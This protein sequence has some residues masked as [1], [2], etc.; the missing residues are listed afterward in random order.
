MRLLKVFRM[1]YILYIILFVA[2]FNIATSAN[3]SAL[4]YQKNVNVQF[5]FGPTLNITLSSADLIIPN[6]APGTYDDSNI[7]TVNVE[8]NATYGYT[9]SAAT[10]N[11]STYTNT[12]LVNSS[13]SDAT[14]KK[15]TSL[16]TTASYASMASANDNYW[17][18]SYSSDNGSTWANYSG[19][20][21]CAP[22]DN[23]CT[24]GT[25]LISTTNA[26]ESNS[27][28][29]KIGAKASSD[30]PAGTYKNVINFFAVAVPEPVTFTSAYFDAGKTMQDGFYKL[31]DMSSSICD[32]VEV[33]NEES[34]TQVIDTR[35]GKIYWIA[36]ILDK[37]S[38]PGYL[39]YD[40]HCWM[41][42]NLD[43]DL[44]KEAE[45][46]S[47]DTDLNQYGT[48]AYNSTNGYS[49]SNGVISWN[50]DDSTVESSRIVNG[51]I[52]DWKETFGPQSFDVGDYYE[53]DNTSNTTCNY[54]V[55][56]CEN[57]SDE[58]FSS[59][60]THGSVG[61]YYNWNAAVASNDT[62]SYN[63]ATT[64][65]EDTPQNSICPKGWKLPS[66]YLGSLFGEWSYIMGSEQTKYPI[67]NNYYNF[68]PI[69]LVRGGAIRGQT[70]VAG[71]YAPPATLNNAGRNANYWTT[72]LDSYSTQDQRP[73]SIQ[74]TNLSYNYRNG[75]R[76]PSSYR[77]YAQ[78]V[79][80]LAR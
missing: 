47:L 60:G 59:N 35:D 77:F 13:D 15:F 3:S 79:R 51:S 63:T 25:A 49:N 10:G 31:Q 30:K 61:N 1:H 56:T 58:P 74:P 12:D 11:G 27:I 69:Y 66:Y 6:L 73:E 34:Q 38:N 8:T 2:I 16:A 41:T 71:L 48:D 26:A 76:G 52:P 62:S 53:K 68:A 33:Y 78:S 57:F 65:S 70:M 43:L 50:P 67:T 20:P 17:G 24:R 36:K 46:T 23:E 7:I 28:K 18:Y 80:C 40:S 55:A 39:D 54:L 19:L 14:T 22:V 4:T 37:D 42:Q 32:A 75:A 72:I 21:Y 29:F 44:D 9:L 45:L 5:T 64:G